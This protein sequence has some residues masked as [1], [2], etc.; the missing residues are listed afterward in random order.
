LAN[1]PLSVCKNDTVQMNIFNS[2]YPVQFLHRQGQVGLRMQ[3]KF[4]TKTRTSF[5]PLSI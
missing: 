3:Q 4:V 1:Q 2:F 5:L